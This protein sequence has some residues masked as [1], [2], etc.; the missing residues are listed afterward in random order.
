LNVERVPSCRMWEGGKMQSGGCVALTTPYNACPRSS[1]TSTRRTHRLEHRTI[2]RLR[3]LREQGGGFIMLCRLPN[4]PNDADCF[5]SSRHVIAAVTSHQQTAVRTTHLFSISH[6]AARPGTPEAALAFAF[7]AARAGAPCTLLPAGS[8][9][10]RARA[11]ARTPAR[12]AR[13]QVGP[14][15]A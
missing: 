7:V 1:S 13:A 11:C 12:V 4:I 14:A 10:R 9:T 2:W 6:D 15:R 5:H 3:P 8:H